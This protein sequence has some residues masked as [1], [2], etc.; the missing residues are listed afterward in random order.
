MAD[1]TGFVFDLDGTLAT[2]PVDWDGVR[3]KLKEV[4]GSAAE[5]KPVFPTIGEVIAKNPKLG[6]SVFAVIDEY[7]WAAV[8]SARLYD[9][10][11]QLLSRLS[12]KA[13]VTLVTMQG[14]RAATRVLEMFDLKQF[15]TGYFTR[16]DSLDRAE[17]VEI[18]LASMKAKKPST[19]FVGDRL[20]DLNAA[21]KVGVPFVLIR[22]HGEDPEEEDTPVYHSVTEFAASLG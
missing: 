9:G 14:H 16:E 22:T 10:A 20:N 2:I 6:K 5:F 21:K 3:V 1:I 11:Y 12:E 15:F 13:K 4:T 7:E 8:P 19:M 17:Q 18:A